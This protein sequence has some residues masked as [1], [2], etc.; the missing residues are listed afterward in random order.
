MLCLVFTAY[1]DISKHVREVVV[2]GQSQVVEK[3][4]GCLHQVRVGQGKPPLNHPQNV[5][6]MSNYILYIYL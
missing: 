2:S 5:S 4:L 1:L 6:E 3:V